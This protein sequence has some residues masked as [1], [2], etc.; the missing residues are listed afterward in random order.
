MRGRKERKGREWEIY[1]KGKGRERERRERENQTYQ[2]VS[3]STHFRPFV[4]PPKIN[5][6]ATTLGI[7]PPPQTISHPAVLRARKSTAKAGAAARGGSRIW[8]REGRMYGSQE[9]EPDRWTR[10]L[11]YFD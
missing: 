1:G 2:H 4:L 3:K 9:E 10:C 7:G 8:V 11:G 6:K 5:Q